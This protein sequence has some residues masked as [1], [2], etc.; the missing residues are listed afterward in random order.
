M[1]THTTST[2]S[3]A[4]A[5][6]VVNLILGA[7]FFVSPWVYGGAVN[8]NAW[9]SWI[10][11][12]LIALFA[13]IRLSSFSGA[14][15]LAW[16]NMILGAWVFVSPWVYGYVANTGRFLNSLCVGVVIFIVSLTAASGHRR[17]LGGGMP[18]RT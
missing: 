1:D 2:V 17:H 13:L 14:R 7:W 10:V 9:N 16:V 12:A 8:A 4:R 11:G 18:T 3:P 5:A 15:A 6:A